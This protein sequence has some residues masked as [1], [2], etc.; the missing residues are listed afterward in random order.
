MAFSGTQNFHL[1]ISQV[2]FENT[3]SVTPQKSSKGINYLTQ[4]K[5]SFKAVR[6]EDIENKPLFR[7]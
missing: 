7:L 4:E 6:V 1:K 3:K 5:C 2:F